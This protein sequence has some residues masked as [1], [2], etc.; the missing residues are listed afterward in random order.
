MDAVD[1]VRQ[2][3]TS[4]QPQRPVTQLI[5]IE[6]EVVDFLIRLHDNLYR[7]NADAI[8]NL[9][10][11]DLNTI[12]ER[13]FK[14]S[15][16]PSISDVAGFYSQ[17]GRFHSLIMALYSEIYYRHAFYLG[18]A[19]FEDRVDS[20]NKY[21]RLLS[22][23]IEECDNPDGSEG[24]DSLTI[25][26]SW[27]WDMLDEFVYQ[28]QESCRWRSRLFSSKGSASVESDEGSS[29]LQTKMEEA[30]NI[31]SV[32]VALE[33]LHK[34]AN[35]PVFKAACQST[36]EVSV[37]STTLNYQL[38]YF[39]SISLL[40]LHVLLGDYYTSLIM[41]SNVDLSP[42]SLYWKIP[43]CHVTLVYYLG[44]SFMM[45]RRYNDAIRILSQLLI[46]LTK[47]RSY[48]VSQSYQQGYMS[49]QTEKMYLIIILCHVTTKIKLDE[50]I[51]QTI[52][53][54]YAN[55]F[56]Q[57][58]VDN[59][60]AFRDVFLKACPK[61]IDPSITMHKAS[62][63]T[64]SSINEP[65][66]RQVQI[67]LEEINKLRKVDEIYSYAKL[68]HNI[69]LTKLASL[70]NI[71]DDKEVL[72]SYILCVKHLVRQFVSNSY[73]FYHA[74]AL[75]SFGD[76]DDL[77]IDQNVLHIK[78]KQHQK[79]YAEYFLQQINK[80]RQT[81]HNLQSKKDE[82]RNKKEATNDS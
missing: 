70:M 9:Y 29:S 41:A 62:D 27:V 33:L 75:Q 55:K 16:W 73:S 74:D 63:G 76:R 66:Q 61:F 72:R 7:K 65:I 11:Q 58:Q 12:T 32:P 5:P 26:A 31:W 43:A 48:L 19:S 18:E 54:Q 44:F 46:F 80:C 69:S 68:Y 3:I 6:P 64:T 30:E 28:L 47:Q 1:A 23:F 22:Y 4:E 38:G 15:R 52:K 24:L 60:E 14:S 81:L 2:P 67:F 78:S 71:G 39:A 57:L 13:F 79:I 20:W 82:Q 34:L 25:P 42:K 21:V 53:E 10:E 40:R 77:Y 59:E 35:N 8:K 37:D 36:K 45:L 49:K 51:L 50:T 17:S 56:Y